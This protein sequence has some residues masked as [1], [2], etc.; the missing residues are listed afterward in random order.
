MWNFRNKTPTAGQGE[1]GFSLLE[2]LV[3]LAIIAIVLI[4]VMRLQGQS[5]SMNETA[6]F[7]SVA[8]FLAQAKMAEVR[9]DFEDFVGGDSGDFGE[10]YAGYNWQVALEETEMRV[11]DKSP[12]TMLSATV[13][14][15]Q[16]SSG[17]SF[18]LA[19]YIYEDTEGL[20]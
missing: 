19:R 20:F 3:A 1:K 12:V 16:D 10:A 15:Q 17:Q 9:N 2:V 6:R 13:T 8:P 18:R 11:D 14:V 5:I 7:Y 4:S